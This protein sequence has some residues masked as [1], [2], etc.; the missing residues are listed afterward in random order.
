MI[1]LIYNK[2][3]INII[4]LGSNWEV[5]NSKSNKKT[6]VRNHGPVELVN[7]FWPILTKQKEQN[8][9]QHNDN[10]ENNNCNNKQ[11]YTHVKKVRQA[12]EFIF[13]FTNKFEK[14]LFIK[15]CCSGPI[16]NVRILIFTVS[17]VYKSFS[18]NLR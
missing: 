14:Q 11:N 3:S 15:N 10:S 16:K 6:K 12:S 4:N 7:W 18:G 2:G 17:A 1:Y 8:A 9:D 5:A 13:G